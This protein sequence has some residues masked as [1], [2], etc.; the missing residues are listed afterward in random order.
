MDLSALCSIYG[1]K[2]D[3]SGCHLAVYSEDIAFAHHFVATRP[4]PPCR[5]A[6]GIGYAYKKLSKMVSN[7]ASYSLN[8][9][10]IELW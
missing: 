6:T 3:T 1:G 4:P 7:S 8:S 5:S 2:N 9:W 10:W